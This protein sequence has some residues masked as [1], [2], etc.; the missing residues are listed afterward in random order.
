MSGDDL[1]ITAEEHHNVSEKASN[2]ISSSSPSYYDEI[3][4]QLQLQAQQQQQCHQKL[5]QQQNICLQT[6]NRKKRVLLVD[7]EA[8]HCLTYQVVLQDAGYECISYMDSIK[9]LQQFRPNYYDLV[10]LDIKMP[11]LDGFALCEKIGEIDTAVQII[12]ITAGEVD[13]ENFRRQYYPKLSSDVNINCI[14]KPIGNEE[15]VRFV[16]VAIAARG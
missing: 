14:Q 16:N 11:T 9:A 15:L 6:S 5:E 12:F 7:D 8:D 1:A 13:Y 3:I 2:I 4:T 10:I